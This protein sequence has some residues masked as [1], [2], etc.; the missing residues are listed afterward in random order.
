[1]G[2]R[3]LNED[4]QEVRVIMGSYG[5]GIER[6]LSAA[7]EL[8]HDKDGMALPATIAPFAVVVTPVNYA[9]AAQRQAA[10]GIYQACLDLSIDALVD[11]RDERP[12]VKFK[13]ADLIGIPYRITIGKKLSQGI[14][15]VVNRRTRETADVPVDDVANYIRERLNPAS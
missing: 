1:M 12:G 15:E 10:G 14:V 8:Y 3:V 5:I 11:D 7:I 2:L 9:D 4:G 13:D 6:I